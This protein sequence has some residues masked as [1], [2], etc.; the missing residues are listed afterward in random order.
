[1]SEFTVTN[2]FLKT[3]TCMEKIVTMN[4]LGIT[5]EERNDGECVLL[6]VSVCVLTLKVMRWERGEGV[7]GC[8]SWTQMELVGI[9]IFMGLE[10]EGVRR[11]KSHGRRRGCCCCCCGLVVVVMMISFIHATRFLEGHTNSSLFFLRYCFVYVCVVQR[12]NLIKRVVVAMTGVWLSLSWWQSFQK[13]RDG[14]DDRYADR[15]TAIFRLRDR[16]RREKNK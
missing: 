2:W 1:M 14:D 10:H 6:C 7:E 13:E 9:M 12:F 4:W 3:L 8:W 11:R 16:Q 5:L 15:K